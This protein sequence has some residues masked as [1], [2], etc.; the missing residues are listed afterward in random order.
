MRPVELGPRLPAAAWTS[1]SVS[2]LNKQNKGEVKDFLRVYGMVSLDRKE[3]GLKDIN[4]TMHQK[5]LEQ[6]ML[7]LCASLLCYNQME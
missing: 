2:W 3:T 5:M 1:T 6:M 4:L 7:C